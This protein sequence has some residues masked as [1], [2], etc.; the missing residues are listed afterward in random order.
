MRTLDTKLEEGEGTLEEL[1]T[2]RNRKF[3]PAAMAA[4]R[5]QIRAALG[6]RARVWRCRGRRRGW[7]FFR[8]E[9]GDDTVRQVWDPPVGERAVS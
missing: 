5:R 9:V 8:Q 2:H 4:M 1:Q 3:L 7:R 6:Q